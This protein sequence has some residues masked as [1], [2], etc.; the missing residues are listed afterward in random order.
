[1]S[2]SE[3]RHYGGFASDPDLARSAGKKGGDT[4]KKKYGSQYYKEIGKKGGATLAQERGSEFY[5]EIGRR[6]GITKAANIAAKKA[7]EDNAR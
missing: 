7:S 4:V 6:G 3:N 1:M 2:E 5:A